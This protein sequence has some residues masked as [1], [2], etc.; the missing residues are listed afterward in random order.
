LPFVKAAASGR[1][2]GVRRLIPAFQTENKSH[3]PDEAKPNA[4]RT[5]AQKGIIGYF[6]MDQKPQR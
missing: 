5:K 3:I 4:K 1:C 2:F 6:L